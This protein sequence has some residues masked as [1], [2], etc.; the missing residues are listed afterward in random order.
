MKAFR[1]AAA[2]LMTAGAAACTSG[3]TSPILPADASY[4]D[5]HT[6]GSGGGVPT[7]PATTSGDAVAGDSVGRGHTLGS[8][9]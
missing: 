4:D 5:G 1:L 2:L 3:S 6:L 8:G 9:G 7:P